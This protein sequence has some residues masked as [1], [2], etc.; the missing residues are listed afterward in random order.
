MISWKS[1]LQIFFR[2]AANQI[3]P[4]VDFFKSHEFLN[5]WNSRFEAIIWIQSETRMCGYIVQKDSQKKNR[6]FK[7]GWKQIRFVFRL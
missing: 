1:L 7:L 4:Q 6:K 5:I 2:I 3:K